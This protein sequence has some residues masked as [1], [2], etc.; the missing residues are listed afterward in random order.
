[1]LGFEL[2]RADDAL[3][4]P[5]LGGT[6]DV[7]FPEPGLSLDFSRNFMQSI[8]GRSN[9]G[10]LGTG[11]VSD[12]DIS[13]TTEPDGTVLV[14]DAGARDFFAPQA[15]GA[16][17]G[18]PGDQGI[19]SLVD[20]SYQIRE[21][22]GTVEAFLKS[23]GLDYVQDS[24]GNR[25]TAGYN[26]SGQMVS[27]TDSDGQ[28]LTIVYDG[29]GHIRTITD[30]NG[31]LAATYAYDSGG[32]LM[33]VATPSGTTHYSYVTGTGTAADNALASITNPDG[34]QVHF[35]YD[36]QGRLTG[37]FA[38]TTASPI[39]PVTLTYTSPGGVTFTDGNNHAT[40]VLFTN[41]GQPGVLVNALGQTT[42]LTYD[43]SGHV[44]DSLLPDGATYS[45]TYDANGNLISQID[46]LDRTTSF[47]YDTNN[48]L[49]SYT[50]AKNHTTRIRLRR[51]QRLAVGDLRQRCAAALQLQPARRGDAVHQCPWERDRIELR[52]RGSAHEGN[53]RRRHFLYLCL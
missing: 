15:N 4:V 24:S 21:T 27:L 12:W 33:T 3:P 51:Q 39:D 44:I 2:L 22:D 48:N 16:F 29:E 26:A 32:H 14:K 41:L 10:T 36:S 11:W 50:D 45:Y 18:L 9:P 23:G 37:S 31:Q 42:Q 25:I 47:T 34:T 6:T 7:S 38:G 5:T 53:V 17:Q 46:P 43:A 35:T 52:C 49:S 20:G 28:A 30:P 19:L 1:M 8:S 13:A 40:T